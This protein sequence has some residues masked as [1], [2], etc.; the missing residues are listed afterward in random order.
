[1]RVEALVKRMR[2]VVAAIADNIV[3]VAE[4]TKLS[5]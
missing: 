1:M 4:L 2:L 3:A 5:P